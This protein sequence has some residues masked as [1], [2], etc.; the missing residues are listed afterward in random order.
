MPYGGLKSKPVF[1]FN[2]ADPTIANRPALHGTEFQAEYQK[3]DASEFF[4]LA[5]H[6]WDRRLHRADVL[7]FSYAYRTIRT[8]GLWR[9]DQARTSIYSEPG[10]R[11][12]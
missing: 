1:R 2:D 8:I 7:D 11:L 10:P 3:G 12:P 5:E 9:D 6:S 4:A